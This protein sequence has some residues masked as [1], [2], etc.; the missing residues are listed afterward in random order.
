MSD[1]YIHDLEEALRAYSIAFPCPG[2]EV[3]IGANDVS[4]C[5]G[6]GDDCPTCA[7]VKRLTKTK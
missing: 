1:S 6:I 2:F 5:S 4:G 3:G 7:T